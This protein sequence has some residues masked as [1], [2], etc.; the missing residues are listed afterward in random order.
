MK[1]YI[2]LL[3]TLFIF[4]CNSHNEW[5]P[6]FNGENLDG[7]HIYG[8]GNDN[9]NGWT[10]QQGVLVY[11]PTQRTAAENANLTTDNSYGNFELSLDWMI[12][13]HGNSGL[14]W[15]VVESVEYEHPYQTGAEI[16][17][18]DDNWTEYIAER[19]DINRAGSLYGM[20]PP[21]KV[22][23]KPAGQWNHYVLHIDHLSNQGWLD[24]NGERVLDFP[25]RGA[26]WQALIAGSGFKDWKGFGQAQKGKITLQDFGGKVAFRNIKIRELK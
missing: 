1:N 22:V 23:S 4:S 16:Q 18:L 10:V 11:D 7:W 2:F 17:I 25:V 9:Y 26:A 3:F 14:F 15:G 8:Q 12:T 21:S 20:M 6:L 19:G 24:F 13:E 5:T